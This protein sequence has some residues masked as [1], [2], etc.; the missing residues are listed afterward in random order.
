MSNNSLPS[1]IK[2]YASPKSFVRIPLIEITKSLLI[3]IDGIQINRNR[4]SQ[5]TALVTSSQ[6]DYLLNTHLVVVTANITTLET[7]RAIII[8]A[9]FESVI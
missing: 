3:A 2:L 6:E 7:F 8:F 5:S 4:I 9:T 1:D